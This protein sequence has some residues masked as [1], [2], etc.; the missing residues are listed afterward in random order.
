[1]FFLCC[2]NRPRPRIRERNCVQ[3]DHNVQENM[4]GQCIDNAQIPIMENAEENLAGA[5]VNALSDTSNGSASDDGSVLGNGSGGSRHDTSNDSSA[6][7]V[8][9]ES[10]S[11]NN[12]S[13]DDDGNPPSDM[14]VDADNS[15]PNSPHDSPDESPS[16]SS[17]SSSDSDE[18]EEG[19]EQDPDFPLYPGASITLAESQMAIL[20]LSLTHKLTGACLSDI[21]DLVSMHCPVPNQAQRSLYMFKKYFENMR[22]PLV[23][24][25][26][27]QGCLSL[28]DNVGAQCGICNQ[29]QGTDPSYFITVSVLSQLQSLYK[30]PGF[31]EKCR[32][33]FN[34]RQPNAEELEDIFDARV[35]KEL[36][37]EGEI[38]S[39]ENS[40]CL[41]WNTDGVRVF[42]SSRFAVW[43][44]FLSV[45]NL[46]FRDRHRLDN[47]LLAGMWFGNEKPQPNLFLRVIRNEI[48]QLNRGVNFDTP[49]GPR[50][51]KGIVIGGTAD[52]P[53]RALFLNL[54]THAGT[55]GCHKCRIQSVRLNPDGPKRVYPFLRELPL[56]T[57]D[58]T[59][60]FATQAVA[61]GR[62]EG[63][64]GVKG[65][66]IM[67]QFV[68]CPIRTTSVDDLHPLY[69]GVVKQLLKLWFTEKHR[70]R[71]WSLYNVLPLI[72]ARLCLITPPAGVQR[73]PRSIEKNLCYLKASELKLWLFYYCLPL[74]KGIMQHMYYDHLKLLVLG[75]YLLSKDSISR[76]DLNRASIL[77]TEFVSRFEHLYTR[78]NMSCNVHQLLHLCNVASD[79]GPLRHT[80]TFGYESLNGKLTKLVKGT[81]YAQLQI[82]TATSLFLNFAA[83]KNTKLQAGRPARIFCDRLWDYKKRM[84]LTHCIGTLFVVGKLHER[85]ILAQH[86]RNA[87]RVV[88]AEHWEVSH[89]F[90]R[91]FNSAT[92][93]L[94]TSDSYTR[95]K[96]TKS[97]CVKWIEANR[98]QIGI[99]QIY[100]R[101]GNGH[102]NAF[103]GQCNLQCYAI[104][105]R[106]ESDNTVFKA[107]GHIPLSFI[108]Q[109]HI[110]D[111]TVAIPLTEIQGI[112]F[113]ININNREYEYAVECVNTVEL[114]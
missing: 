11:S 25:Y 42:K 3:E 106:C 88:N 63:V 30:Q 105:R 33:R 54:K 101:V 65:H 51:I 76:Q 22:S 70:V 9:D 112:C 81:R 39:E 75:S 82:C 86:I 100:V 113:Y 15:P 68:H 60:M 16:D 19:P 92:N 56:R 109:I 35:F 96:K 21:L 62:E 84:R 40:L 114:E 110:T 77:L 107:L 97:S 50:L 66:T 108:H 49:N 64:F 48:R 13:S 80:S 58:E 72:D 85:P 43:P 47:A 27:C 69:Q 26:Y 79:F 111:E 99:V 53:A 1:M 32:Y 44:F 41:Q 78:A 102:C 2:R 87:L 52:L 91:F 5:G 34:R 4:A 10:A 45:M 12:G 24:H 23:R 74:L 38:L 14:D 59:Y 103:C 6:M 83:Y 94:F 28:L 67:R 18:E 46:P 71:P 90:Y 61:R 98:L 29:N 55:Y 95:A 31:E 20:S 93:T 73:L 36:S 37:R 8:S 17:S 57:D 89:V 104:V 7:S